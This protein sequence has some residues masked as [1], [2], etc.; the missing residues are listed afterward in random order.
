[1]NRRDFLKLC[2][3][4]ATVI[5]LGRFAKVHDFINSRE[6]SAQAGSWS[7]GVSTTT[8]PIHIA[9]LPSG[10]IFYL[11]G[12]GWDYGRQQGPYESRVRNLETG[13]ENTLTQTEDSFCAGQT[14]LAD[15]TILMA[16]G[17]LLYDTNPD[18]CNGDWHGLNAAYEFNPT[19]ETFAKVQNMLHGRWY[20]TLVT[21]AD[22][23]VWCYNGYDEYGENNRL[24]EVYDPATKTW[25]RV[26][27]TTG[28]I[29]YTVGLGH[30]TTCPGAGSPTYTGSG[31]STGYYPRAHFMP[32]GLIMMNGFTPEV[33]SWNPANGN[34]NTLGST[35]I[36]RHYGTSF[37]L[38]LQNTSTEKGKILVCGGSSVSTGPSTISSQILDFNTGNPQ[39]RT[40]SSMAFARKYMCPVI[41]PNG[42]CV[43]FG[44]TQMGNQN[45]ILAPELFD[46]DTETWQVLPSST[47]ARYYHSSALLLQ[48]GRVWVAGGTV[49]SGVWELR[50]EFFSPDYLFGGSRPTISEIPLVGNYGSTIDIST[51][52]AA[53]ISSVSLVRLMN[54]THHYD[55]NQR[56]VWLQIVG[57]SAG[58][59]TVSAPI[60]ANIAPPGYYM[61]HILNSAGVP[62]AGTIIQIPGTATD[63]NP[64]SQVLGLTVTTAGISQLNLSW[65]ANP[66]ADGVNRYNVYR[67]TTAGFPVTL[68]TTPPLATP[69]TNSYSNTGLS[70]STTYYYKVA[71]VD[72]A[73][74]IGALSGEASGT[75]S[76][77]DT[78]IPNLAIT[79]PT[80]GST[81][82]PGSVLVQGT[83]SDNTGGSG[84]RDVRVRVDTGAYVTATPQAPGNW[85]TWSITVSITAE[86]SHTITANCRD[87]A[88]NFT[89][90]GSNITISSAPPDTTIPNLAITSPTTG[91]TLPPGSVLVQGTASDN[92]GG[93]GVRDVRVRVDTG[94]Y[95]TA[96]PQAPGNW[97][98]WSITVSIT[99][100]G[101]HTITANCRDNA[102]NFRT[103]GSNITISSAPPDTTI[104]NVTITSSTANATVA[105]PIT[106]QGTASDNVGVRDVRVRID[107][108]AYQTAT[109]EA[110]SNWTTWSISIASPPGSHRITANAR[111]VAGNLRT[112]GVTVTVT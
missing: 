94:A 32:S 27:T 111:D 61:I 46:P 38:P 80:T 26:P 6:V 69:N 87:N 52:D 16:G 68:G 17:T 50:T 106:V 102:G 22:G 25:T 85:S 36:T 3:A 42:K 100:T 73:G 33:R 107:S 78:T 108:G 96:T 62:S 9:L 97:S 8:T 88:G 14:A 30:E 63:T 104:P 19:T 5:A 59:I 10:R 18:N 11:A 112:T 60:N 79:S 109:P 71:A 54:T 90:R 77:P 92:T 47:I 53:A 110:P 21:M 57:T 101:S 48:D 24:V 84:V 66:A 93:S 49:N 74:N 86:G 39:I 34:W 55:A 15:G 58:G 35:G 103:R 105:S 43:I 70:A 45:P 4:T 98:T 51:P 83:A 28:G 56:L 7:E 37:L 1:M 89:T 2:G 40:V 20:P 99:A 67:G 72:T 31:P 12:S 81:L 65:T 13:E 95:V 82:P 91:S 41:L 44:G 75:T 29:S 23:K 76:G 64:P